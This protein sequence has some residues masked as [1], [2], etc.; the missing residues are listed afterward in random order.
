MLH[1]K[2]RQTGNSWGVVIPKAFL[3]SVNINPVLDEVSIEI[4]SDT[5]KLKKYKKDKDK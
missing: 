4:E 2:L 3:E 1:K 5:I